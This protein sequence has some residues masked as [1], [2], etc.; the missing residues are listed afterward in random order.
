VSTS[1][2]DGDASVPVLLD[3]GLTKRL[4]TDAKLAFAKLMHASD[5]TDVD[6]LLQSFEEMGLEMNRY[7]PF[8]DMSAMQVRFCYCYDRVVHVIMICF[9][10]IYSCL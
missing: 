6:A 10:L 8:E 2:I 7:D 9:S 3:F 1:E 4:E 5:E